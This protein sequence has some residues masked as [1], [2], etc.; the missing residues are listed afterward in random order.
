[1][2][3]RLRAARAAA[4]T[5]LCFAATAALA[6]TYTL[7]SPP[8]PSGDLFVCTLTN[9]SNQTVNVLKHQIVEGA[10]VRWDGANSCTGP[11][12]AGKS[13]TTTATLASSLRPY[14]RAQYTGLDG[15]VVGSLYGNYGVHGDTSPNGAALAL[16]L[17]VM[18]T[19]TLATAN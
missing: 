8:M 9:L 16:P 4:V 17:Q 11:L 14:C 13:C 3:L 15:A 6:Q 10:T 12:V 1:M 5:T 2:N 18:K 19:I 7:I